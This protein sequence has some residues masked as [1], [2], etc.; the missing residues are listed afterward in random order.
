VAKDAFT[1]V[2]E[3]VLENDNV[4]SALKHEGIDN[5]ISLVRLTDDVVDNLSYHDPNPN[6]QKFQK[7]ILVSL[8]PSS[9][10]SI[11]VKRQTPLVMTGNPLP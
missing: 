5:I 1:Y 9:T 10:M 11:F 8:N 7:V 3:N 6:I 4:T 2:V